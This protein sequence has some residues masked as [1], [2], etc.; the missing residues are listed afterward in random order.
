[1]GPWPWL[2]VAI[3]CFVATI[4]VL[5]ISRRAWTPDLR[6]SPGLV[7]T[8]LASVILFCTIAAWL[9]TDR[10]VT[11]IEI[12]KTGGI[13]AASIVALYGIWLNDRRRR[14]EEDRQ[15]LESKRT[16]LDRQRVAEE[17]F[18][19]AIQLFGDAER[20]I[21]IGG[22]HSLA[23]IAAIH[24]LRTQSIID[25]IC[26]HL[27]QRANV[28]DIVI[29]T[30]DRAATMSEDDLEEAQDAA[31]EAAREAVSEYEVRW[32]AQGV[33]T[34]ILESHDGSFNI[35]LERA[36]LKDFMI[37]NC[38][39]NRLRLREAELY[40]SP[41]VGPEFVFRSIKVH[42]ALDC[43][44]ATF[45]GEEMRLVDCEFNAGATFRG[46]EL[47]ERMFIKSTKFGG[48][49]DF[50]HAVLQGQVYLDFGTLSSFNRIS[51]VSK[52]GVLTGGAS[53]DIKEGGAFRIWIPNEWSIDR[54]DDKQIL[55][56]N[57]Y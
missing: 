8:G 28:P 11:K 18:A 5:F 29:D 15:K 37:R 25:V 9:S 45:K 17:G 3:T 56:F 44:A 10:S 38:T 40:L 57:N 30:E 16:D 12:L 6:K 21:R 35:D 55:I 4:V 34:E 13:G 48:D 14:T 36:E 7:V 49:L 47:P 2:T 51:Q 39:I 50:T 46:A 33:L 27:R 24:P 53:V 42:R 43:T 31:R 22:L 41:E 1:M 20:Q 52:G 26:T 23:G 19:R 32:A 54:R